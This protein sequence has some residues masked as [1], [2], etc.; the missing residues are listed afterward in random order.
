MR[1]VLPV[2]ILL[3]TTV[4]EACADGRSITF[5]SDGAVVEL[6]AAAVR[7]IAEIPLPGGMLAGSLRI[8]PE[9]G[10]SI[11]R[12][13]TQP[14]SRNTKLE[15]ELNALI[16]QRSR[17][18]DRLRALATRE[19]IFKSAAKSQSG[20]A[21]R[22]TKSNP[23]PL[24]TIRQ[25]TDFAIA[26]LETVYTARRRAEREIRR[27]DA[28]IASVRKEG[29][30]A[31]SMTRVVVSPGNGRVTARFAVGGPGWIPGYDI[32][33]DRRGSA[34]VTL[35]G[36][37]PAPLA[38]YQ[39]RVSR[40]SLAGTATKPTG[41]PLLAGGQ[42]TRLAEYRMPIGEEDFENGPLPSFVFLLKNSTGDYLPA[43]E[44]A[45][46]REGEYRGAIR[47]AG[48]SSG[49]SIRISTGAAR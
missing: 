39:T 3:L 15:K 23:D 36:H 10:T 41:A 44:A 2:I 8:S 49:R 35:Y 40:T 25:G 34:L 28:R 30:D 7:G 20:K 46:Y 33:V 19:N 5:F 12:V 47:F 1:T 42:R 22:K 4:A 21:P 13:D 18:E 48:L 29:K 31:T 17:M 11:L 16:E 14:L 27:I 24:L 43:G 45:C 9:R 26:Q 38:G 37:V 32:R 6:R